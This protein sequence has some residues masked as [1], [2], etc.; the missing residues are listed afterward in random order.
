MEKLKTILTVFLCFVI[1]QTVFSA[2]KTATWLQRVTDLWLIEKE[3]ILDVGF[4]ESRNLDNIKEFLKTHKNNLK[5][6]NNLLYDVTL[7]IWVRVWSKYQLY[8]TDRA[9]MNRGEFIANNLTINN[10]CNG[11]MSKYYNC[12]MLED[13]TNFT[14]WKDYYIRL[15]DTKGKNNFVFDICPA[16][17]EFQNWQC[18]K[19]DK[20]I[21]QINDWGPCNSSADDYWDSDCTAYEVCVN[22]VCKNKKIVPIECMWWWDWPNW[23]WTCALNIHLPIST[24]CVKNFTTRTFKKII[25]PDDINSYNLSIHWTK[26]FAFLSTWNRTWWE[27]YSWKSNWCLADND[28][29]TTKYETLSC[30]LDHYW[31]EYSPNSSIDDLEKNDEVY[32]S[33]RWLCW[34]G[35]SLENKYAD[36]T[37]N[38]NAVYLRK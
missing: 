28:E 34:E 3:G 30:N 15:F 13:N 35:E 32:L 6:S 14:A 2:I 16:E 31:Q 10:A 1:T 22:N 29:D 25:W 21:N 26:L 27:V 5:D 37:I 12:D 11:A 36:F 38:Y 7:A 18:V 9:N 23:S 17:H 19:V 8:F 33:V 24:A 20:P 4:I